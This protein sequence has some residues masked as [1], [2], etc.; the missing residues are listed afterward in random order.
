[1]SCSRPV[2]NTF[3]PITNSIHEPL[4]QL[5]LTDL[6][7]HITFKLVTSLAGKNIVQVACGAEFSLV[8]TGK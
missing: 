6:N 3:S 2:S 4:L 8:L 7:D 1:M 5:G